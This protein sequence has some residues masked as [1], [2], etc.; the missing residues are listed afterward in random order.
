[1]SDVL[2]QL[3]Q[4]LKARKEEANPEGSYV[5]LL[6]QKGL[7]KILEKTPHYEERM[8]E[9]EILEAWPKIVGD[10]IARHAFPIRIFE[11]GVLL[12]GAETNVWL[13]S[14]KF[15]EVQILKKY[16]KQFG[17]ERVKQLRFKLISHQIFNK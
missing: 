5:A 11:D 12:I 13:H 4:V 17:S 1:M 15:L 7:N 3:S 16:E 6:H 14:L 8:R 2:T 9:F 10:R